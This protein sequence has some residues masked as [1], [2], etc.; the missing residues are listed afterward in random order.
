MN[1]DNNRPLSLAGKL[2]L[3]FILLA[4]GLAAWLSFN[5]L[6]DNTQTVP[7]KTPISPSLKSSAG[8]VPKVEQ[9]S[10]QIYWVNIAQNKTELVSSS[11]TLKKS[12]DEITKLKESFNQLLASQNINSTQIPAGTRLLDCRIKKDGIH[13]N[14]SKEFD[15][16]GGPTSLAGRL[17]Q[18][19][20]TATN[21]EQDAKV[22]ITLE[23]QPLTLLGQGD[24][25][26]V[27]QP[28]SRKK[29]ASDYS[30]Q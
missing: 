18:V 15:K 30:L 16:S 10:F 3:L 14:L 6:H 19:V 2:A 9:E 29:F 25:L 23:G 4:G 5:G 8:E 24:G 26:M 27:D 22:W 12:D 1:S 21:Q 13:L 17:A 28:M 11:I 20:Y 7:I